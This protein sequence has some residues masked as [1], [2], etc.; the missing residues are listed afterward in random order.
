MNLYII[1]LVKSNKDEKLIK[2]ERYFLKTILTL[3]YDKINIKIDLFMIDYLFN[4][5]YIVFYHL[6]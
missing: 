2:N 1:Y 4:L 3:F 6:I 5:L